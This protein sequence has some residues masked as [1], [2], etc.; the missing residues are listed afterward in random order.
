M[1]G[2]GFCQT[3]ILIDKQNWPK[4]TNKLEARSKKLDGPSLLKMGKI[5]IMINMK[6]M[7]ANTHSRM[8]S[9]TSSMWLKERSNQAISSG[10]STRSRASCDDY[11][12]EGFMC[13]F[14]LQGFHMHFQGFLR[15]ARFSNTFSTCFFM[16]IL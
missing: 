13:I 9:V 2:T 15:Y 5:I 11:I 4:Q 10:A 14:N 12:C 8:S 7:M 6:T 3:L 16:C 1:K